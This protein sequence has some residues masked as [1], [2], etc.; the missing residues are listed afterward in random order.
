MKGGPHSDL[1]LECSRH[2]NEPAAVVCRH[3]LEVPLGQASPGFNCT[4]DDDG[5]VANCDACE[6][7]CDAE[8]FLPDD[9]VEQSFVA[10]C[11][12]CL[13]EVAQALGATLPER[14]PDGEPS[15]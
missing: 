13:G 8:G 3:L 11:K 2:G 6:A 10:I 5:Y 1:V 14:S 7:E 4:L 15:K 9:L 12:A